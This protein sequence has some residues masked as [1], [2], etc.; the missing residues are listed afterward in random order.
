M[1]QSQRLC[2]ITPT[3][4]LLNLSS[5]D[6][7]E[8]HSSAIMKYIT[9]RC[10]LL[11][12]CDSTPQR[13]KSQFQTANTKV[14][15][16][17]PVKKM[18]GGTTLRKDSCCSLSFQSVL[19]KGCRG[20]KCSSAWGSQDWTRDKTRHKDLILVTHFSQPGPISWSPSTSQNITCL[21]GGRT[22]NTGGDSPDVNHHYLNLLTVTGTE[23]LTPNDL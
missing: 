3:A 20:K 22:F 4:F 10:S 14:S 5:P 12:T 11:L 13:S 8:P 9:R 1:R 2:Q 15:H 7:F 23:C 6:F 19:G 17:V 18:P 16:F 21:L